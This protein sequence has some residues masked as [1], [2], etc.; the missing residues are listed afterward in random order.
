MP[1]A[2]LHAPFR[3]EEAEGDGGAGSLD[4]PWQLEVLAGATISTC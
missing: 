2:R 1:Y 3:A 4:D